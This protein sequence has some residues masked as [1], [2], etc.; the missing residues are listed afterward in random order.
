MITPMQSLHE[1]FLPFEILEHCNRDKKWQRVQIADNGLHPM[2]STHLNVCQDLYLTLD[3]FYLFLV[4]FL[5]AHNKE[6][7]FS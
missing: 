2:L 4:F 1:K 7:S 5:L 3:F 6:E